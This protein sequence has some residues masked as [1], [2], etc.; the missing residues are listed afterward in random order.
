MKWKFIEGEPNLQIDTVGNIIQMSGGVIPKA[1]QKCK[2]KFNYTVTKVPRTQ[3]VPIYACLDCS[4]K[5]SG[6]SAAFDH[7]I[8][9]D[10]KIKKISKSRVVSVDKKI[11]GSTAHITKTK[12]D[13]KIL[14]GKCHGIS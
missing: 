3:Q 8:E 14:C 2:T 1:C 13:I 6:G 12:N 10:H 7:K 4:F 5:N 9:T 11:L